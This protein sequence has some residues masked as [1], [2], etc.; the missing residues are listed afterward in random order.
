MKNYK[1]L[2]EQAI[3]NGKRTEDYKKAINIIEKYDNITGTVSAEAT[4]PLEDD[5]NF[6][7]LKYLTTVRSKFTLK[8]KDDP[9]ISKPAFYANKSP[10]VIGTKTHLRTTPSDIEEF[11]KEISTVDAESLKY[12]LKYQEPLFKA[13][14]ETIEKMQQ[15]WDN[16]KKA[17]KEI[18]DIKKTYKIANNL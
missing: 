14:D 9:E 12:A 4:I 16:R 5:P 10:S 2:V 17:E 18:K 8:F 13:M 15:I 1:D 11:Q 3:P 7:Q 6:K